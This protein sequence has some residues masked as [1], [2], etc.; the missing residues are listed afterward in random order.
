MAVCA[1]DG[2]TDMYGIGIRI[3]FYLQWYG[4]IFASWL[5]PSEVPGLRLTIS[6]FIAATFLALLIQIIRDVSSLEVVEVYIILL[7]TF[8]YY[9]F[10]VPL[11]IW[12]VLTRCNPSLDPSRYPRVGAGAVYSVLSFLLLVAVSSFQLWFWF[13]RVPTLNNRSCEEYGFFFAKVRMN[14]KV[15]MTVNIVLF[16]LLFVFCG[17]ILLISLGKRMKLVEEPEDP[18]LGYAFKHPMV[19]ALNPG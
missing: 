16:F 5:A 11:Y 19:L 7:L 12:R 9:L 17:V 2:N 8:G 14:E 10:L 18:E 3:G 1:I 4:G 13:A 6:I 15:F